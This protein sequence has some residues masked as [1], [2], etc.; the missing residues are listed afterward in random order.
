MGAQCLEGCRDEVCKELGLSPAEVELSMGM[1]GD[2]EQ[3]VSLFATAAIK[4]WPSDLRAL[5]NITQQHAEMDSSWL[6]Y[7]MTHLSNFAGLRALLINPVVI[8][9]A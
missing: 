9:D 1:S 7:T 5:L 6:H 8:E 3:A 4:C 2:F